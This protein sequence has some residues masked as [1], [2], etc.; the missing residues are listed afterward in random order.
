MSP[1]N[2]DTSFLAA[3]MGE[4][5]DNV[6]K[7]LDEFHCFTQTG[8][9]E[10]NKKYDMLAF[11]LGGEAKQWF[12]NNKDDLINSELLESG[13]MERFK[14]NSCTVTKEDLVKSENPS[15]AIEVN[16][17]VHNKK[18]MFTTLPITMVYKIKETPP[19]AQISDAF[20]RLC[21]VAACTKRDVLMTYK[22]EKIGE[23]WLLDDYL[24]KNF[25]RHGVINFN[26][27]NLIGNIL[28]CCLPDSYCEYITSY[29]GKLKADS[30]F[31]SDIEHSD[32]SDQQK[33]IIQDKLRVFNMDNSK[34]CGYVMNNFRVRCERN[35]SL[36]NIDFLNWKITSLTAEEKHILDDY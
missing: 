28:L 14:I 18:P 10:E 36:P 12:E 7:W 23:N 4:T 1:S 22:T 24:N 8:G 30:I 11:H 32:L 6:D 27:M 2:L 34:I 26:T 3:F 5:G 20:F 9:W 21:V 17:S 31:D 33:I 35:I 16:A 15:R 29:R 13:L 25:V 19:Q